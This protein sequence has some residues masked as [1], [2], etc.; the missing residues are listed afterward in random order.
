MISFFFHLVSNFADR[1][2]VHFEPPK[3]PKIFSCE[4]FNQ[5]L[6]DPQENVENLKEFTET[7]KSY[8]SEKSLSAVGNNPANYQSQRSSV[9][10]MSGLTPKPPTEN[11][12]VDQSPM[13]FHD[14]R[15]KDLLKAMDENL[16]APTW[17]CQEK[18]NST[19]LMM[20]TPQVSPLPRLK[21]A[22]LRDTGTKKVSW[23]ALSQQQPYGSTPFFINGS[24]PPIFPLT[25]HPTFMVRSSRQSK[26]KTNDFFLGSKIKRNFVQLKHKPKDMDLNLPVLSPPYYQGRSGKKPDLRIDFP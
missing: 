1:E 19:F 3:S 21:Q 14:T 11:T 17:Q 9:S 16:P 7:K 24:R 26:E 8:A 22:A 10:C 20:E 6:V 12:V 13:G 15:V 25:Q 23:K 18:G 5:T 4:P 2:L